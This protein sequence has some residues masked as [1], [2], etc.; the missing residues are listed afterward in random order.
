MSRLLQNWPGPA[1]YLLDLIFEFVKCPQ[2][3]AASGI[4]DIIGL[5]ALGI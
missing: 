4:I 1:Q 5:A 3:G 2:G